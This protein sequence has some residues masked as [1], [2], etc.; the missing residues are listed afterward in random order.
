MMGLARRAEQ[1][2]RLMGEMMDRVGVDVHA[3]AAE[4]HALATGA[5]RCMFCAHTA[6]CEEWLQTIQRAQSTPVFCPNWALFARCQSG[7][8]LIKI[9]NG[10]P[11]WAESC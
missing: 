6:E 7:P 4:G 2:A 8:K 1:R 5:R 9:K 10:T 11:P 3:A